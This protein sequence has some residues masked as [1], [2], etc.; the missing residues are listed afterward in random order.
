MLSKSNKIIQL[1]S[2][3]I[4][5]F[6]TNIY[7]KGNDFYVYV[8]EQQPNAAESSIALLTHPVISIVLDEKPEKIFVYN[9]ENGEEYYNYESLPQNREI[10]NKNMTSIAGELIKS[11]M[12]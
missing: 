3:I 6:V 2:F 12:K 1:F 7:K 10:N 11:V 9:V 8:K 5:N 4:N